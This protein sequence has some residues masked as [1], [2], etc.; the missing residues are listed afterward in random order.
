MDN[1]SRVMF[2]LLCHVTSLAKQL[3]FH[4]DAARIDLLIDSLNDTLLNPR[5]RGDL[6]ASTRARARRVLATYTGCAVVTCTLW[7]AFSLLSRARTHTYEFAFYTG[8]RTDSTLKFSAVLLYS[9]YVTTMVAIANTTTDAFIATLLYQCQTQFT[10][11]RLNLERLPE[12]AKELSV[13][14]GK[15]FQTILMELFIECL[16]H[17]KKITDLANLLLDIFGTAIM[18]QFTIGGWILCMAAYKIVSLNVLSLEFVS[19]TLFIFCILTELF[20]Y[21]YFGNELTVESDQLAG[22]AYAMRWEDT[23]LPFRRSLL[24]LMLRARR[25]LRPAAGRVLPLS[26]E[27]FLKILKSSYTFYAVLRQTK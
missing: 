26:L 11:L 16:A 23:S 14:L 21:C 15:N 6:L 3:V 19:M 7:L 5:A 24:L 4:A 13:K 25:P 17:H 8:L 27:T 10:I 12:S 9:Y 20:L 18:V 1:L 2:L 22:A